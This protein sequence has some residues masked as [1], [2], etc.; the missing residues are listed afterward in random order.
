MF[1]RLKETIAANIKERREFQEWQANPATNHAKDL[2]KLWK[3][4]VITEGQVDVGLSLTQDLPYNDLVFQ[5][6][7]SI[8]EQKRVENLAKKLERLLETSN[9]EGQGGV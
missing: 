2:W 1:G 9:S 4:G 5:N 8:L 6:F 7:I 3:G